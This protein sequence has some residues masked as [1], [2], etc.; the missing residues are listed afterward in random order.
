MKPTTNKMLIGIYTDVSGNNQ[1]AT[2][3]TLQ[4]II[5]SLED[6]TGEVLNISALTL[7]EGK[8]CKV[9]FGYTCEEEI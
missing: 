9:Y 8:K 1:V 4:D 3:E 2:G 6:D 7:Y 5:T